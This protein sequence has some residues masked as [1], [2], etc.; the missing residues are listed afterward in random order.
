[1]RFYSTL[2]SRGFYR[3]FVW[4]RSKF[5]SNIPHN[6]I[7]LKSFFVKSTPLTNGSTPVAAIFAVYTGSSFGTL[8]ILWF[9]KWKVK[10]K[11]EEK[12]WPTKLYVC[13]ISPQ[14]YTSQSD[15]K[16]IVLIKCFKITLVLTTIILKTFSIFFLTT[17]FMCLLKWSKSI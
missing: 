13:T 4:M 11:S 3:I 12:R 15:K 1:M 7:T 5:R 16:S 10:R 9:I 6:S 17:I 2:Y 8:L 14:K